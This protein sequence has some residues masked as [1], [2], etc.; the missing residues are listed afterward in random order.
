M[1]KLTNRLLYDKEIGRVLINKNISSRFYYNKQNEFDTYS[2]SMSN[3][4]FRDIIHK[5]MYT[6]NLSNNLLCYNTFF[7]L[8]NDI[9]SIKTDILNLHSKINTLTNIVDK[10]YNDF[11][12]KLLMF[13]IKLQKIKNKN[14]KK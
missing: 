4:Y 6:N 14:N 13:A 2:N 8:I 7:N 1:F 11:D 9:K 12:D 10:N 3:R 5:N